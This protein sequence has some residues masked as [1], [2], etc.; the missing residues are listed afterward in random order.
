MIL[1]RIGFP[2]EATP[3]R[4]SRLHGGLMADHRDHRVLLLLDPFGEQMGYDVVEPG[5]AQVALDEPG[6][7]GIVE[8]VPDGYRLGWKAAVGEADHNGPAGPQHPKD[9]AQYRDRPL[10]V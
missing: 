10:E 8:P 9:L 6:V 2:R 1:S 5:F 3:K 4:C 7:A